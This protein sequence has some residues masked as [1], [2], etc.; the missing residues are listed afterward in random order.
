MNFF[1]KLPELVSFNVI[2]VNIDWYTKVA[3][4]IPA[5]RTWTAEE[6]A[7]SDIKDMCG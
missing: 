5:E 3:Y 2:Q 4:Y 6:I 1:A 7:N